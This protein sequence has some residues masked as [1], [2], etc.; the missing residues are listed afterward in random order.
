MTIWNNGIIFH[1]R[2]LLR[3]LSHSSGYFNFDHVLLQSVDVFNT[4]QILSGQP[5][6]IT[7]TFELLMKSCEAMQ[8]LIQC[9]VACL[10]ENTV[11]CCAKSDCS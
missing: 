1:R 2:S 8:S 9:A 4:V 10:S 7:E 6:F 5:T 11:C 3:Q